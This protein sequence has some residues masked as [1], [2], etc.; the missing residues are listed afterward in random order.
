[1]ATAKVTLFQGVRTLLTGIL[2]IFVVAGAGPAL[3]GE[4]AVRDAWVRPPLAAGRPAALYFVL[5]N[6]G[7]ATAITAVSSPA[8]GRAELHTHAMAKHGDHDVMQ[9]RQVPE[10]AVPAGG[11]A[12]LKPHGDHVMLFDVKVDALAQGPVPFTVTLGDGRTLTATAE[13]K[14]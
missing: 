13:V 11:Q 1:M 5:D 12:I 4:A 8:A 7:P 3:A 10:F 2:A 6:P 9:M 14:K